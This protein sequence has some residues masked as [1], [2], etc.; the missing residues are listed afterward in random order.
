MYK[1]CA[2]AGIPHR[3]TGKLILANTKEQVHY[4]EGL[5]AK[6]KEIERLGEGRVPLQW[7]SGEEVRER[8]PDVSEGV[9]GALLSPETGIVSSH[10]FM[11]DLEKG[12]FQHRGLTW[13]MGVER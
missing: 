3:K 12:A 10:E 1:R 7:L 13:R 5:Q 8:E 4:L 9:V 6:A 2:A 11:A